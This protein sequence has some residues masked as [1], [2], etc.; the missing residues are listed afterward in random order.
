MRA[1]LL[2]LALTVAAFGQIVPRRVSPD[3]AE[4]HLLRRP[5]PQYPSLAQ[6]GRIQGSVILDI[7]IDESGKASVRRLI[8][9][10]PLLAPAA[11]AAV[12]QA[13]YQPF[14]VNGNP[15]P[16]MT[17]V[18]VAFGNSANHDAEDREMLFLTDVWTTED[19]AKLALDKG[20]YAAAEQ[21]MKKWSDLLDS[22]RPLPEHGG[23]THAHGFDRE[24]WQWTIT[25]GLV[26]KAEQKYGEAER[27][28]KNALDLRNDDKNAPENAATLAALGDLYMDQK[29][30]DL[31]RDSASRSIA[32]YQKNFKSVG[33]GN[34]GAR[35]AY[36]RA[37]AYQSWMVSKLATQQNEPAEAVKQ[38]RTVL[39][40]K[41]YLDRA[42]GDFVTTCQQVISNPGPKN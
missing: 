17:L 5:T 27:Y 23:A 12:E 7:Q 28:Y 26:C 9:G 11:I 35:Q 38:C 16:V 32:I 31:A 13:K 21:Q 29:R 8:R 15:T 36:G 3:E 24:L 1:I 39:D 41:S 19:S 2:A 6:M 33:S 25:M 30:Y 42:D 10:H 22:R 18:M 40:F 37:I 4:K 14:E 34:P 20:D